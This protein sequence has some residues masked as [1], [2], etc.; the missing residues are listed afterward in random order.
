MCQFIYY[1]NL[2]NKTRNL[3]NYLTCGVN[4]FILFPF[5]CVSTYFI[6]VRNSLSPTWISELVERSRLSSLCR[7]WKV[8]VSSERSLLL[9]RSKRTRLARPLKSFGSR[10][11]N[12]LLFKLSVSSWTSCWKVWGSRD[13]SLL[14]ERS[15]RVKL[16]N[17]LK[18]SALSLVRLLNIVAR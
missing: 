1:K 10:K 4:L 16:V 8:R 11:T 7:P 3:K 15:M 14:Y 18:M 17:P 12:S 2:S 6:G 9:C 13:L 5:F